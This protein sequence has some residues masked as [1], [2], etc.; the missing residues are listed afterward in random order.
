MRVPKEYRKSTEYK[1]KAA[2][3]KK[4]AATKAKELYVKYSPVVKAKAKSAFLA[5]WAYA[6]AQL[7]K[8]KKKRRRRR[9]RR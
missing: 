1:A 3:L 6:K 7:K 5:G 2:K 4:K 8:R 9:R